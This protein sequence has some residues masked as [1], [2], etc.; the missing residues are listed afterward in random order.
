MPLYTGE[1][2]EVV[3]S[4]FLFLVSNLLSSI[5]FAHFTFDFLDHDV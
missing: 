4:W 3:W 5:L 2:G 1:S